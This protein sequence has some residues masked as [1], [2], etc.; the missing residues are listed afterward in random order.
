MTEHEKI[1]ELV[2]QKDRAPLTLEPAKSALL[3][4]D[5]Q[6]HFTRPDLPFGRVFDQLLPGAADGYFQR[7]STIVLPNIKRLQERFRSHQLPVIFCGAGG[8]LADGRDLPEFMRDWDKVGL[9]ML[10]CRM[11]PLVG[12]PAWDFDDAVAPLSGE[13]VV[14]KSCTGALSSTK[15]DQ[16]LHNMNVNSL[17]V[18]GLTTAVCVSQTAREFADR[19]FRVLM[20]DDACTELSEE[21]H[22]AAL[23]TFNYCYGRVK[24]TDDTTRYF[25]GAERVNE[26]RT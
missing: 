18:C 13:M 5:V 23:F 25:A 20:V 26:H 9:Q 24:T 6:R 11:Q 15:L 17:V 22:Q 8:Y 7:V 19:G 1:Q 2:R 16:T 10:G 4:I 14:N 21:M 3:I 12:D